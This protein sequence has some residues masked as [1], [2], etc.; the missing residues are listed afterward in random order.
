[1][2]STI[3]ARLDDRKAKGDMKGTVIL[4]NKD[5]L[6]RRIYSQEAKKRGISLGFRTVPQVTKI[7]LSGPPNPKLGVEFATSK[8]LTGGKNFMSQSE[9]FRTLGQQTAVLR[10][11]KRGR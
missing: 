7:D 10:Y 11:A 8:L 2:R 9:K 1:M 5:G 6:V 3:A 4:S